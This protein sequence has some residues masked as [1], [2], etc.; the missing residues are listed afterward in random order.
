MQQIITALLN[1]FKKFFSFFSAAVITSAGDLAKNAKGIQLRYLAADAIELLLSSKVLLLF[2]IVALLVFTVLPAGKDI[3]LIVVEDLSRYHFGNFFWLL[4]GVTTW[5]V[6]AEY[7]MRYAIYVTDNSGHSLSAERILWRKSLQKRIAIAYLLFPF[8]IVIIGLGINYFQYKSEFDSFGEYL[9]FGLP[10]VSLFLIFSWL[11]RFY[12]DEGYRKRLRENSFTISQAGV[13][14]LN[15]DLAEDDIKVIEKKSKG[16]FSFLLLP[17]TEL[18]WV[19][20]LFGIYND[21]VY[22][23]PASEHFAEAAKTAYTGFESIFSGM[24]ND[25]VKNFP[26]SPNINKDARIPSSF[27][28]KAFTKDTD[29]SHDQK[30]A[31]TSPQVYSEKEDNKL[32]YKWVYE[33]PVS[34]RNEKLDFYRVLHKQLKVIALVSLLIIIIVT[35]IPSSWLEIIGPPGLVCLAFAA[36]SGI[37]A[38]LLYIDFALLRKKQVSLRFVLFIMLIASSYFNADHPYRGNCI[39]IPDRRPLLNQHFSEWV[40]EYKKDTLNTFIS[41]PSGLKEDTIPKYPVVFICAEGGALRTGAYAAFGLGYLQDTL[42]KSMHYDFRKSI[43]AFSAVSGGSVG[44]SLFNAMAYLQDSSQLR[45]PYLFDSLTKKFFDVDYLSPVLGKMFYS[46][47]IQ[48]FLPF[49]VKYFDRAISLEQAW[50]RGYL[51]VIKG[52]APS[53]FDKSYQNIYARPH[54]YPAFFINTTEVETGYQAF[55]SNVK[56]SQFLKNDERDLLGDS[57]YHKI[58]RDILYSTAVNFSSRFPL[59]S[60][61]AAAAESDGRTYHYIDG[62]YVENTGAAT[63][64]EILKS[65]Q[66]IIDS[67]HVMPF[68]VVLKFSDDSDDNFSSIR[69]GNEVTEIVEGIYNTRIGRT[70]MAV[71]ALNRYTSDELKGKFITLALEKTSNDVPTNW[72]LSKKSAKEIHADIDKKWSERYHN[73]LNAAYFLDTTKTKYLRRSDSLALFNFLDSVSKNKMQSVEGRQDSATGKKAR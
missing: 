43:Y 63:M 71:E 29:S 39:T 24:E 27:T 23:L 46:E 16:L 60:P 18:K 56:P 13:D 19:S 8:V 54:H 10:G 37:Y 58:D 41:V 26:Q 66:P 48:L 69:F 61:A 36:W 50:E 3:L 67:E 64:I 17:P 14:R 2:N 32:R 30:I 47:I 31:N 34:F 9:G 55:I 45:P 59:I 49:H 68:V 40:K 72:A 25:P 35:A 73:R 5:G 7:A 12:M 15:N 38:G 44:I 11:A 28:L 21:Y 22:T 51:Q 52:K 1:Y 65:L 20:F 33:I 53:V 62:G 42:M 4:L 57:M 6:I 70:N